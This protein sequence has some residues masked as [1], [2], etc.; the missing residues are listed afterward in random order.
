MSRECN[1]LL[2]PVSEVLVQKYKKGNQL[3]TLKTHIDITYLQSIHFHRLCKG[4]FGI[5]RIKE[6]R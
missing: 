2:L 5:N 6:F 4:R 1:K 3:I